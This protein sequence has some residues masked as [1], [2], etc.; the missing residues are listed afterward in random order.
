MPLDIWKYYHVTHAKHVFC[1]PTS[2]EKMD[3]LCGLLRLRP[4]SKVVDIGCGKGELMM[5]L[6]RRYD[7]E[8]IGVDVS[9][10]VIK[11]LTEEVAKRGLDDKITVLLMDGAKFKPDAPES[12]DLSICLGA[13]WIW[14]DYRGTLIALKEL[15]KPGGTIVVGE[16]FW[17][18]TPDKEYLKASG[19]KKEL[20]SESHYINVTKAEGLGL[21]CIY[22]MVSNQDEWDDYET[23]QW[24]AVD[25]YALSHADDQD[26]PEIVAKK[27]RDKESYL[28]W[29][30]SGLGWA[31]YVFRKR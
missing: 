2:A 27:E 21:K 26:M 17:V 15:V 24:W 19:I 9:P 23:R 30:R 8:A 12:F 28:K 1:N 31:I 16:P 20:F 6:A 18:L 14:G 4:G 5:R 13:T 25:E 29:E 11:E 7:V 10:F 3:R 22:T